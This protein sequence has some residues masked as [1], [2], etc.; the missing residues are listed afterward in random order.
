MR[1]IGTFDTFVA[2]NGNYLNKLGMSTLRLSIP[3]QLPQDEALRRI[4]NMLTQ[5]K[6]DHSDKISDLHESWTG[7]EGRFSFTAQGFSV[8]GKLVVHPAEVELDAKIPF[9]LSL[10][11]G[12][13]SGMIS[14]RASVL[15]S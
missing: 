10:F 1:L 6:N 14:E 5:M 9:A 7:Y 11:K 15:L 13:I 8:T 4:Q 3:H 2:V 12:A